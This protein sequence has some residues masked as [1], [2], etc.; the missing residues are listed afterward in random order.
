M[1]TIVPWEDPL[2][3]EMATHSSARAWRISWTEETG[4]LQSLGSQRVGH[5]LVTKQ[6]PGPLVENGCALFPFPSPFHSMHS[7][8]SHFKMLISI[9]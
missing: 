2:E 8:L 6:P 1:E 3:K 9:Y 7:I 4:E 5:D